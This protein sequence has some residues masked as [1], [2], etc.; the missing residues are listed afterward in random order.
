KPP[1]PPC[2]PYCSTP[3]SETP[4]SRGLLVGG[5]EVNLGYGGGA[6]GVVAAVVAC[7]GADV[8]VADDL[9]D[10]G[11]VDARGQQVADDRTAD[12]VRSGAAA[13]REVGQLGVLGAADEETVHAGRG[14]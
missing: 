2:S 6:Y 7:C 1:R 11:Q 3:T 4:S 12:V 9:G 8:G 14:H 10:G 13:A 5:G